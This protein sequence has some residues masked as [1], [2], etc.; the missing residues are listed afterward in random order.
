VVDSSTYLQ[1]PRLNNQFYIGT[2]KQW[3]NNYDDD[4]YDKNNL[5]SYMMTIIIIKLKL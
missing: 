2:K 3:P 1:Y 5:C 4:D